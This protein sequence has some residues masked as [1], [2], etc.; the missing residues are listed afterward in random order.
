MP[1][2]RPIQPPSS[3]QQ[4]TLKYGNSRDRFSDRRIHRQTEDRASVTCIPV[5]NIG[6]DRQKTR[7]AKGP[8]KAA[9]HPAGSPASQ[10]STSCSSNYSNPG[11]APT[12]ASEEACVRDV[13]CIGRTGSRGTG[14]NSFIR[15][16]PHAVWVKSSPTHAP[17]TPTHRIPWR[18]RRACSRGRK[19]SCNSI[20]RGGCF[21]DAN[22]CLDCLDSGFWRTRIMGLVV[23]TS[24]RL[25]HN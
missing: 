5:H 2:W 4:L 6:S 14:S 3:P 23:P 11:A 15:F 12:K 20:I 22:L 13:L 17:R 1:K 21:S 24:P 19:A 25:A 16:G 9:I 7:K 18:L 10:R 8:R